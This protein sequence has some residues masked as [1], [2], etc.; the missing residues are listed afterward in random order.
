MLAALAA[1]VALGQLSNDGGS[2]P[3]ELVAN[4]TSVPEPAAATASP[5]PSVAGD[6]VQ[7]P[8]I[9][10]VGCRQLED[11]VTLECR[12]TIDGAAD[13]YAWEA[14][15]GDPP[16]G[17]GEVF[18]TVLPAGGPYRI[19]LEV[20]NDG[21]CSASE[22]QAFVVAVDAVAPEP[23]VSSDPAGSTGSS[24]WSG[25]SPAPT[26]TPLAGPPPPTPP[27]IDGVGCSPSPSEI[28]ERVVCSGSF[29]GG[30]VSTFD[31]SM[32]GV[33]IATSATLSGVYQSV[34][35]RTIGLQVCNAGG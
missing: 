20:C 32:N 35:Q 5:T 23:V 27:S 7:A 21:T 30:P 18:R 8:T 6:A 16:S 4:P 34:G 28:G 19:A 14:A 17:D 13:G 3:V 1:F 12:P 29:S 2:E 26:A 24:G 10:A 33:L 25:A 9:E 15:G 22:S 11:G 31:W